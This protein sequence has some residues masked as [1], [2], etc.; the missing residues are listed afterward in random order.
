MKWILAAIFSTMILNMPLLQ[1]MPRITI[2]DDAILQLPD[3]QQSLVKIYGNWRF[4]GQH[5]FEIDATKYSQMEVRPAL[6]GNVYYQMFTEL[7]EMGS[8]V[9]AIDSAIDQSIYASFGGLQTQAQILLVHRLGVAIL[10]EDPAFRKDSLANSQKQMPHFGFSLPLVSGRN[11]LIYNYRQKALLKQGRVF[12]NAGLTAPF[13]IGPQRLIEKSVSM[14]RISLQVPLGVFFCLAIYSLLIYISRKGEDRESLLL[15]L[16]SFSFAI[17][18]F[19]S[20]SILSIFSTNDLAFMDSGPIVYAVTMFTTAF[21][22]KALE[23][24]Y[25]IKILKPLFWVTLANA[26]FLYLVL[27]ANIHVSALPLFQNIFTVNL[28]VNGIIFFLLFL[29]CTIFAAVQSKRHD[30]AWFS[31][32]SFLIGAGTLSDALKAMFDADRPWLSMWGGLCFALVLAK[33]NSLKFSRA[34]ETSKNLNDQLRTINKSVADLNATLEEKVAIRTSEINSLLQHIPQGVLS[35]GAHGIIDSLYSSQLPEI[36][37]HENIAQKSFYEQILQYSDLSNDVKDQVWQSLLA[38]INE[39]SFGFQANS[40]N[41]PQEIGYT[42]QG[43]KKRLQMTWNS[44]IQKDLIVS[45]VLITIRDVSSEVADREELANKKQDFAI[46]AQ[47]I[48]IGVEKTV[49]FFGSCNLLLE[50]SERLIRSGAHDINTLRILFVNMHTVKGAART[51]GLK[52]MATVFHDVE[53]YYSSLIKG[54]GELSR[55]KLEA[56]I[57]RAK[58]IYDRYEQ[59]NSVVLGRDRD[60]SK[61]FISRSFLE[62]NYSLLAKIEHNNSLTSDIKEIIRD[63]C[64]HLTNLIFMTVDHLLDDILPQAEKI[65]K[66]LSKLPPRIDKN[67][68]DCFI[69]KTQE[70]ALKNAFIHLLRNSLDDGIEDA[71]TRRSVGKNAV[72]TISISAFE[73]GSLIQIELSDDGRGFAIGKMKEKGLKLGLL[74]PNASLNDIFEFAF[75]QGVSTATSLTEISGRGVG[76]DAVR[77]FIVNEGGYVRFKGLEPVPGNPD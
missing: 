49:Q 16:I 75:Q 41:F 76:M 47:L 24:Q 45:R 5:L 42:Y 32:G 20:Q 7:P 34:F 74:K 10:Y 19:F 3:Q 72:G 30:L 8:Y 39:Y 26:S 51:L 50:E 67:V 65:A 36:L 31:L 64:S 73:N 15:F 2:S 52:D 56:D 6:T 54:G 21:F 68:D 27:M 38:S 58:E 9:L 13:I 60:F 35:V 17:K 28:V 25:S 48:E 62:E 59:I 33:N 14:E 37:G 70:V 11:Y 18:E 61:M 22:I 43:K 63:N 57:G 29:P 1:G 66:D 44:E 40:H 55:Q 69:T 4:V 46:V 12:T 77:R 71:E 53:S 23:N